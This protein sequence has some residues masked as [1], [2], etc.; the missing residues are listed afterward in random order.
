MDSSLVH[1]QIWDEARLALQEL[2][3]QLESVIEQE[4]EPGLGTGGLGRLAACYL[5]SL[6]T[7]ST[8]AF[9]YGIRYEF[10][11]FKQVIREGWQVEMTD[12][13][14]QLGNPWEIGHPTDAVEVKL[15]GHTEQFTN[16][17]GRYCVNWVPNHVVKGVPYDTPVPG[18]RN[19]AVNT[20]RLW[21]AE[22]TESFDF[23]KFNVGDYVRRG[24]TEGGIGNHLQGSLSQRSRK[25]RAKACAW[26]SNSFWLRA[27]SRTSCGR[28][29]G[30]ATAP[31]DLDRKWAIQLNGLRS[32]FDRHPGVDAPA[33]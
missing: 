5:D 21:R 11:I 20:L 22:A 26:S 12:K 32:S 8:P 6:A 30:M 17:K 10:G 29:C 7:L 28:T 18:Y 27:R 31:E 33:P 16:E 23:A 2:G 4:A 25:W 1:R 3:V 9:G 13:W 14:L 15:G 24:A 19:D